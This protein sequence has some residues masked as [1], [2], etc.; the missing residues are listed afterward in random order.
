MPWLKTSLTL[1]YHD[2]VDTFEAKMSKIAKC[3]E[4][5][6]QKIAKC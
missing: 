2:I 1:L 6:L 5:I 4:A 3:F